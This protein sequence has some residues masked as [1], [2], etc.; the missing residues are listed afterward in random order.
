MFEETPEQSQ[1]HSG[2]DRESHGGC[3]SQHRTPVVAEENAPSEEAVNDELVRA[4]N[5]SVRGHRNAPEDG[6]V[7]AFSDHSGSL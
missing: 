3:G 1:R 2:Q 4:R 7:P 5:K 6:G